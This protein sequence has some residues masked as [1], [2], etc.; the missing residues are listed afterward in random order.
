MLLTRNS[1]ANLL[2]LFLIDKHLSFFPYL[3]ILIYTQLY[4]QG[5]LR[6][7]FRVSKENS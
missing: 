5:M 7:P 6:V 4:F 3:N 2:H 1:A